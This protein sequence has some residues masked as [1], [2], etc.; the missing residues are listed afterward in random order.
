MDHRAAGRWARVVV[1]GA[2]AFALLAA[3][4]S[5]TSTST[6]TA[7]PAAT[8]KPTAKATATATPPPKVLLDLAGS[9]IKNSGEFATP[10]HWRIHYTYDCSAFGAPTG[11]FQVILMQGANPVDV[12]VN[13]VGAK[14]D[15]TTD[16]Y[17]RGQLH[18]EMNS[19]CTWHVT[20]TAA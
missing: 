7:T 5:A 17:H 11:N 13:E 15:A 9:G 4:G 20:A 12:A 6:S 14:G 18:L 2:F 3:C 10:A 8:A 16:V 1:S 19:E